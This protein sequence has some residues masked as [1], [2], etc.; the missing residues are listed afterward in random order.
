MRTVACLV[1]SLSLCFPVLS[2]EIVVASYNVD[3]YLL[4]D[5]SKDGIITKTVLK[6]EREI[7]AVLKVLGEIRPDILGLLEIGDESMF[8]D[9]Q[10]RLRIAGLDYSYREWVKGADEQRHIGLLSKFPI[11]ARN[12]RDNVPF[13]IE[14]KVVRMKRGILDVTVEVNPNYRLRLVGAHLK[15]RRAVPEYDQA[16]MRAK[17]AWSLREHLIG[18]LKVAPAVNLLLF[19]DLN[20]TKNE[21]PIRE[22]I[23]WKGVPNYMMDLRLRDTRGEHWTYYWKDADEY[24]RIDYLLV[25]PGLVKEVILEKSGI[26]DSPLWNEASDHRAIYAVIS[27]TDK[28]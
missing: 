19:G 22:I 11:V 28:T 8:D 27:P 3:S 25:S 9:L 16:L 15:S 17:E 5:R 10:Q 18:I 14:G 2:K 21:Y 12:S 4:A 20:D 7:A 24:S 1:L 6:P 13:E 23:G 26:N